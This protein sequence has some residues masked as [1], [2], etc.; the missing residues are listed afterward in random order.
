MGLCKLG[1]CQKC[2]L[3]L[4]KISQAKSPLFIITQLFLLDREENFCDQLEPVVK[5]ACGRLSYDKKFPFAW[6]PV[7]ITAL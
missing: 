4:G 6:I 3:H 7:D 2:V 1:C 5:S